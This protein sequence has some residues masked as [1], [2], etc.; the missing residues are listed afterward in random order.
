MYDN[1]WYPQLMSMQNA[2]FGEFIFINNKYVK[3][4]RGITVSPTRK[5][6]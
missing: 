6:N 1:V 3:V 2:K 5:R 4:F